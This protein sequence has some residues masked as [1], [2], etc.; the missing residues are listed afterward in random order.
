LTH[1]A[2]HNSFIN[3]Y[4]DMQ[5]TGSADVAGLVTSNSFIND[6]AT[7]TNASYLLIDSCHFYGGE[8][9]VSIDG[10]S[11][12]FGC[13]NIQISNSTFEFMDEHAIDINEM[14]TVL[15]M[16]NTIRDIVDVTTSYGIEMDDV[17]NFTI[18]GN[19]ITVGDEAIS[20]DDGNDGNNPT[21]KSEISNNM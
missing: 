12:G 17:N 6:A 18:T 5:I 7:G 10:T 15:I 13:S 14:D 19:Y 3:C 20:I 21:V 9:G 8:K 16:G 2:D 4:F 1:A 11:S